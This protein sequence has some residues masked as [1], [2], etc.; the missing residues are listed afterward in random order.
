[1]P[2]ELRETKDDTAFKNRFDQLIELLEPETDS[3]PKKSD[4]EY[5]LSPISFLIGKEPKISNIKPQ[6]MY[7]EQRW[8]PD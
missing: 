6:F 8:R 1:M 5:Y 4:R 2:I 7:I 3:L